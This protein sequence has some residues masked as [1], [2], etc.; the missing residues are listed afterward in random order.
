MASLGFGLWG[1]LVRLPLNLPLP[2]ENANWLTF[3]GPLMVCGFLGTLIGLERAVG[4]GRWWTYLA[5]LLTAIG[6]L[7][8]IVGVMDWK[9]VA[10]LTAGSAVFAAVAIQVIAMRVETFT[11]VMALGALTWLAGNVLWLAGWPFNRVVPWWIAF[12]ALTIVGERLDLSRFQKPVS[13]A[14]PAMWIAL[15]A[16]VGGVIAT[17]FTPVAGE[18]LVGAGLVALALW[19]FRFDVARRTIRQPGLTRFMAVC[20]LSGFFWLLVAGALMTWFAPLESGFRYDAVL[21]SFFVGF[22]FAMIFGHAPVIFPAVLHLPINFRPAFYLHLVVLHLAL[23]LR[24]GADLAEWS[25][26]RQ[27]GGILNTAAIVLFLLNT[28]FSMVTSSW[29]KDRTRSSPP[30]RTT[31]GSP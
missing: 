27:F 4:L 7:A 20:L 26:G 1:G 2:A 22:V 28:V 23:L 8:L 25:Q 11:I 13:W 9:G 18:R 29:S 5:P 19:C 6:A 24:V 14:P 12:L 17:A 15:G 31:P 3:H 16:F 30:P 21:H 10:L